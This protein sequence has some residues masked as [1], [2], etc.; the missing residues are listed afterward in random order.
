MSLARFGESVVQGLTLGGALGLR[1]KAMTVL[2]Q[3]E[4][5]ARARFLLLRNGFHF[6]EALTNEVLQIGFQ[7]IVIPAI[8]EFREILSG[9]SAEFPEFHHRCDSEFRRR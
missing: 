9:D 2:G 7:A 1:K 5:M 8:G 3:S 4:Q 6:D